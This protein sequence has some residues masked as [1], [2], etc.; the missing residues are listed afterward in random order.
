VITSQLGSGVAS[1]LH[2]FT[3]HRSGPL[4]ELPSYTQQCFIGFKGGNHK[5]VMMYLDYKRAGLCK[6]LTVGWVVDMRNH[7]T[8]FFYYEFINSVLYIGILHGS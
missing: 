1:R 2:S 7:K 6:W 8:T 3:I 4:E 5:V